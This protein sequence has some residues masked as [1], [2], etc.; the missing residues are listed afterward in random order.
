M[1]SIAPFGNAVVLPVQN[2]EPIPPLA[3]RIR[4]R[5]MIHD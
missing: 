3:P 5:R 2:P 1:V 4:R